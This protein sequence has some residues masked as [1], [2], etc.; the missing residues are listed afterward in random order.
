[1]VGVRLYSKIP[2]TS[3]TPSAPKTRI[4]AFTPA[5]RRTMAS[6]ISAQASIVA[7]AFSRVRATVSAP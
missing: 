6:S 7:P 4:S 5:R 1:M 3:L 2:V